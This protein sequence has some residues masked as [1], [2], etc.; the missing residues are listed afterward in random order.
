MIFRVNDHVLTIKCEGQQEESDD[1]D[2][3]MFRSQS[4]SSFMKS[5]PI[6]DDA[7]TSKMQTKQEE[8]ILIITLPKKT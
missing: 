3:Q 5:I 2:N 4:Y 1:T 6:P 8:D 7:D